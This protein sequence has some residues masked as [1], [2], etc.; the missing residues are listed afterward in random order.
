[1]KKLLLVL[2]IMVVSAN[3]AFA[4]TPM[5][6]QGDHA[7][8]FYVNGL[9][10]FGVGE[11]WVAGAS[12]LGN[13]YGFGGKY[14]MSQD[15]ALRANLG[16]GTSTVKTPAGTAGDNEST[17]LE[18]ALR[19]GLEWHCPPVANSISPYWGFEAMFGYAKNTFKPAGGTESN[20]SG[21]VFGAGVFAGA[22]WF[23]WDAISFNA[24]YGLGFS[25]SSTKSESGGVSVDGPTYTNIGIMSWAVGLNV[26]M[27]NR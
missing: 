18:I 26:Y 4:G 2:F 13:I 1:M 6:N 3:I 14:F 7:L 25:S 10:D 8:S 12:G 21:Q 23:P 24:E 5:T 9:G 20:T 19:P 17:N 27:G 22:E 16:F 11:V 15:M